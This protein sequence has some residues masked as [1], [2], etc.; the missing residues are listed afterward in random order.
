MDSVN[1]TITK[2][3]IIKK[4]YRYVRNNTTLYFPVN[5]AVLDKVKHLHLTKP[6]YLFMEGITNTYLRAASIV[7]AWLLFLCHLIRKLPLH[8]P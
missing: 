7:M 3:K 1:F 8:S 4:K 5:I 2:F 6:A